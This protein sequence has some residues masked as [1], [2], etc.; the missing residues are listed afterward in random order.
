MGIK[1]REW[2]YKNKFTNMSI[3]NLKKQ[4]H[5]IHV[6]VLV[7]VWKDKILQHRKINELHVHVHNMHVHVQCNFSKCTCIYTCMYKYM[8]KHMYI[9]KYYTFTSSLGQPFPSTL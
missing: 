9:L 1:T 8:Y 7:H 3:N 4:K 5:K 2:R 6:N